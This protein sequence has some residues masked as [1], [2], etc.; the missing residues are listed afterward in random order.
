M[1]SGK[2]KA[3]LE[4]VQVIPS[5]DDAAKYE[6][7]GV[8]ECA[9]KYFAG[10]IGLID[11]STSVKISD[12]V[13]GEANYLIME[14]LGMKDVG[15]MEMYHNL[16]SDRATEGDEMEMLKY[17]IALVYLSQLRQSPL[18]ESRLLRLNWISRLHIQHIISYISEPAQWVDEGFGG[19][20]SLPLEEANSEKVTSTL[21]KVRRT[22]SR[23]PFKRTENF[24]TFNSSFTDSPT[25]RVI[26]SP[27]IREKMAM[28]IQ[29]QV[30]QQREE[31]EVYI[32]TEYDRVLE[33]CNRQEREI[34]RLK[35]EKE[36]LQKKAKPGCVGDCEASTRLKS[37]EFAYH[38]V[39]TRLE[40]TNQ[41]LGIY[42]TQH[43]KDEA[44]IK[45]L[46]MQIRS[47]NERCEIISDQEKLIQDLK[48]DL[49]KANHAEK[50]VLEQMDK[51]ERECRDVKRKLKQAERENKEM[52]EA[53]SQ[54]EKFD[55]SAVD[56][57]KRREI[58]LTEELDKLNETLA[59]T[60]KE[61]NE[62]FTQWG[63]AKVTIERLQ[64][65][66]TRQR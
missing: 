27:R 6:K 40:N 38:G 24:S 23:T 29:K 47:L 42:E 10:M 19:V 16:N 3:L 28:E 49:K 58:E 30:K 51:V 36:D 57:Y 20:L 35:E 37:L 7:M 62:A 33:Q 26:N 31:F 56:E 17:F 44:F 43:Q 4:Y 18:V 9:E 50:S 12:E 21:E 11:G 32:R 15:L 64:V 55:R 65:C 22:P 52:K 41:T 46:K 61:R 53:Q 66:C 54:N 14:N 59:R 1:D 8:K 2:V 45:D 39:K 5:S 25:S 34:Q 48:D 60:K 13:F 63:E